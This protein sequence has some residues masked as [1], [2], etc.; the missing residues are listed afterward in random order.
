MKGSSWKVDP[1]NQAESVTIN[2]V[3]QGLDGA[4]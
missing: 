3:I 1:W 4:F 2:R